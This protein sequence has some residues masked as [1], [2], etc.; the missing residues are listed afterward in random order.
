MRWVKHLTM[1]HAD[2][3]LSSISE[4]FGAEAY[5][6]YWFIVEHIAAPLEAGKFTP[7]AVHSAAKWASICHCSAR[8]F[9]SIALRM[10]EKSL[11]VVQSVDDRFQIEVPKILKYKDEYSKK[12]G[13]TPEQDR[14]QKESRERAEKELK[15][16][17]AAV[18]LA[19]AKT[20][21]KPVEK[22]TR[23]QGGPIPEAWV[24]WTAG[25][26]KWDEE[27][28]RAVYADFSDYWVAK[29]TDATKRDWLATWRRWC[30]NN[31]QPRAPSLFNRPQE[32][33]TDRAIQLVHQR[34]ERG[35]RPFG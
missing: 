32:S 12:S 9:K 7:I 22:G 5:G 33:H 14:E 24:T 18:A 28:I 4:E 27:R 3:A 23:F 19:T 2:I 10:A 1:A 31:H 15:A 25:D 6:V 11:I 8:R 35:E 17:A 26:R 21:A 20:P 34:I 16:S 29:A 13:Q 30:R